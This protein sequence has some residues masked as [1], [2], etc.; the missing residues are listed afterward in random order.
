MSR[1][2]IYECDLHT[3]TTRSDGNDTYQELIAR[4][5][6]RGVK[7]VAVTDHDIRP[8][9]TIVRG[10]EEITL[11]H[12]AQELG[13]VV[14]PGIEF[15][16]NTR[17]E[18]VHVVGLCCDFSSREFLELEEKIEQSKLKGYND[19]CEKLTQDG[20]HVSVQEIM[21]EN[22]SQK[23]GGEVQKK[24]IFEAMARKGY[25]KDWQSAKLLVKH[26]KRYQIE[27]EKPHAEDIIR[28]IKETGGTAILAHPYLISEKVIW[29]ERE[30]SRAA[31]IDMLIA[32]GLDGIEAAYPYDK[33]SYDGDMTPEQIESQVKALYKNRVSFMSGGS[34]Y[35]HD[36]LKGVKNAREIGEKGI[37][38]AEL[39]DSP[40]SKY[41]P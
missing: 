39:L 18:D 41:L 2:T 28:L 11:G 31:Y 15:S 3:H 19:L 14:L 13:I 34:D 38:F 26:T 33:T 21:G 10:G 1:E 9:Q 27:R 36:S 6:S 8:L 32:A 30:L 16:C 12:Y 23:A 17:T 40:L 4:A 37:S 29:K 35:H 22:D 7:V 5:V 25:A 20:M 24:Q